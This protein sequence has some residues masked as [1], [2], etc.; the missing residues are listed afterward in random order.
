MSSGRFFFFQALKHVFPIDQAINNNCFGC[1]V[2][3][4]SQRQHDLC[5][6]AGYG[7]QLRVCY[8]EALDM[9]PRTKLMN[10][11]ISLIVQSDTN[12]ADVF[13]QLFNES[14]PLERIK[15]D[16]EMQLEFICYLLHTEIPASGG[17]DRQ[18]ISS[19]CFDHDNKK[20]ALFD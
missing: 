11:L 1:S 20:E 14:D 3:H 19:I 2:H 9:V 13:R 6:M 15:H 7:E 4:P 12:F 10:E 16:G 8:Q 17:S 18:K 5:L